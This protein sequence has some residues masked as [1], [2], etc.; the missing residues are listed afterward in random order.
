MMERTKSSGSAK[1][2]SYVESTAGHYTF[3][4]QFII[5]EMHLADIADGRLN[6]WTP[7]IVRRLLF[8]FRDWFVDRRGQR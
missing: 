2:M 3:V 1:M 5:D 6:R 7:L 4:N 8:L